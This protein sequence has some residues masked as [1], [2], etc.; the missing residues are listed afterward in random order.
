V[1]GGGTR[2]RAYVM[3]GG[4]HAQLPYS[5]VVAS[6]SSERQ[7]R[8]SA[9]T[10]LHVGR[11]ASITSGW[12]R[13]TYIASHAGDQKHVG[14]CSQTLTAKSHARVAFSRL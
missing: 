10:S 11:A 9:S 3:I 1:L 14:E 12:A 5:W 2:L 8:R 7:T 4:N 13:P 6:G